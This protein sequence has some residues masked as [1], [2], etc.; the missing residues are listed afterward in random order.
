MVIIL[1][2]LLCRS[3]FGFVG[4]EG[5]ETTPPADALA[6]PTTYARANRLKG[7]STSPCEKGEGFGVQFRVHGGVLEYV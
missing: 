7:S 2:S 3:F 1:A 6:K 5:L 4:G